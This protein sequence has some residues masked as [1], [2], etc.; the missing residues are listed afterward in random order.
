[1][2]Q[3]LIPA[4]ISLAGVIGLGAC[5]SSSDGGG[6]APVQPTTS[7][8]AT[9]SGLVASQSGAGLSGARVEVGSG[10]AACR[11]AGSVRT[12]LGA[13]PLGGPPVPWG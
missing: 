4:L 2:R 12:S 8:A 10:A 9:V 7:N 3:F 11:S 1:M 13:R 6:P 5:S